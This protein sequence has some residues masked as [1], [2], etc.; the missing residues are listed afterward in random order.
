MEPLEVQ[1]VVTQQVGSPLVASKDQNY[2]QDGLGLSG[3]L[4]FAPVGVNLVWMAR[5]KLFAVLVE[6]DK[7]GFIQAGLVKCGLAAR[8]R[9]W[10][11]LQI[12]QMRVG[13]CSQGMDTGLSGWEVTR[14]LGSG[15]DLG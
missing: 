6:D 5:Q 2:D 3:G 4:S 11:Q 10:A 15:R 1:R 8:K 12:G 9:A 13:I 7:A 14:N